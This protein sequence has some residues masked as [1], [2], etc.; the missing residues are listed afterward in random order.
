MK[1]LSKA[2]N[3][4]CYLIKYILKCTIIEFKKSINFNTISACVHGHN[5]RECLSVQRGWKFS[6]HSFAIGDRPRDFHL[7]LIDS[8]LQLFALAEVQI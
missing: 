8:H 6:D 1:C 7:A 4:F 3:K 2:L 5:N